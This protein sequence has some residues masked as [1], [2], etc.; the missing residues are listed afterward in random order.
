M[1][2][3]LLYGPKKIP[4]LRLC[5]KA[6]HSW[7]RPILLAGTFLLILTSVANAQS[8]SVDSEGSDFVFRITFSGLTENL[9]RCGDTRSLISRDGGFRTG[10][11][12]VFV[13]G[14]K[15]ADTFT[16]I[17]GPG[18]SSV[19]YFSVLYDGTDRLDRC[20]CTR[21]SV[22]PEIECH[23]FVDMAALLVTTAPIKAPVNVKVS[24]GTYQS[25]VV[26]TWQKGSDMP[27]GWL[28]YKI[29]RDNTLIA[30]L[31]PGSPLTYTDDNLQ[32]GEAHAYS[33]T[34]YTDVLQQTRGVFESA[35]QNLPGSTFSVAAQATSGE[36]NNR[37]KLIWN[38][39]VAL[40]T[41]EIRIERSMPAGGKEEIAVVS[42]NAVTYNDYDGIPGY[43]YT[44]TITPLAS[45]KTFLA[46]STTGYRRPN[47]KITGTVQSKF[48]AGVPGVIVSAT[49]LVNGQMV[50]SYDLNGTIIE[51]KDTT[52]AS[53]FY[54][55]NTVYYF[56]KAEF[57]LTAAKENHEFDPVTQ[58]R[59]LE[60]G[61]NSVNGVNFTDNTVF[62]IAGTVTDPNGC[63]V[64]G[65]TMLLDGKDIGKR[66]DTEG[67]Y[68][69]S[70]ENEGTYVV[71]PL[72][73]HH[74]FNKVSES[75]VVTEG[76]VIANFVD[77]QKDKV[78]VSL[79]SGCEDAVTS[80][81]NVNI[82][83]AVPS[84]LGTFCFDQT[85][86]ITG[87]SQE[88][89]LPAQKYSL[90]VVGASDNENNI[91]LQMGKQG[92][93]EIDLTQ[94]DTVNN[95]AV[96]PKAA[97]E[98]HEGTSVTLIV[99]P[100]VSCGTNYVMEQDLR[101]DVK[102]E[103]KEIN[104]FLGTSCLVDSGELQITD[105]VGDKG[106]VTLNAG[107]GTV[108]YR[109]TAG[110]PNI[111][112]PYT[113]R[114]E[115]TA[116]V[117]SAVPV[118]QSFNVIVTGGKPRVG[119][120]VTRTP[121]LPHLI[122]H[123]P[124]G[125]KSYSFLQKDS[126]YTVVS[127]TSVT[128][129]KENGAY[130][131][132]KIGGGAAIPF[133]V[134]VGGGLKL[135]SKILKGEQ[136][137]KG[138]ALATTITTAQQ[139]STA[140]T[141][142]FT[143]PQGDVFVG[144]SYNIRY[145]LIDLVKVVDCQVV[146]D[147][148]IFWNP[149]SIATTYTY[150]DYQIR[151]N[152][153]SQLKR[154]RDITQKR[155]DLTGLQSAKDTV[156]ILNSSI[157]V[158]QQVLDKN[159]LQR[160]KISNKYF[161]E[162]RSFSAGAAFT[163]SV[164]KATDTTNTYDFSVFIDKEAALG[165]FVYL[166]G[167]LSLDAGALIN[168]KWSTQ[169]TTD[170]SI[171]KSTTIGYH[172]DDDD[173][174]D[175]FSVD[176]YND[177]RY[178]TPLFKLNA[179]TSSCPNEPG[180]QTR[181]KPQIDLNR[182]TVSN[183]PAN[184]PAVF[185]A[186]IANI[187]ESEEGREYAVRVIPATNMDGA[188]IRM[189]GQ[190]ISTTPIVYFLQPGPS[191]PVTITVEKGPFAFNYENIKLIMYPE[192]EYA[193]FQNGG[194][195]INAD[196][197]T[198]SV[199][200][201]TQCSTVQISKP[202]DNWLINQGSDNKMTLTFT[203]YNVNNPSFTSIGLQF[204]AEGKNWETAGTILKAQ[205]IDQFKDFAW[206]V[207]DLSKYADGKYEIRAFATCETLGQTTYS[208][209]LKGII[210]RASVAPFGTPSPADGYLRQGQNIS[211]TFDKSINCAQDF[212]S[213]V[214]LIRKDN[215][216]TLPILIQCSDNTLIIKTDPESAI[217]DI[218]LSGIEL[219]ATVSGIE[220]NAGNVQK[221]P[222]IWS[223][224]VNV[225]P[226][227]WDPDTLQVSMMIRARTKLKAEL[228]NTAEISKSFRLTSYP[229]WLTPSAEKGVIQPFG[230]FQLEFALSTELK[231]GIYEGVINA[232]VDGFTEAMPV[233]LELLAVPVSWNVNPS[234]YNH[235]M[236]I[237][238]QY[239][240]S[241]PP[242]NVP[243]STDTRDVIGVFV[244]G[245]PR[246]VGKIRQV[247]GIPGKYAAFITV[248]SNEPGAGKETL[249]FRMWNSL[250]GVVYGAKET[251][252]FVA[253]GT[254]GT[255]AV[256]YI[257]HPE[258]IFQVIPLNKGWNWISFNV[259]APDMSREKIFSSLLSSG[260]SIQIKSQTD[261]S[262]FS[263]QSGWSGALKTINLT[264]GYMVY[265]SDFPDT[266]RIVGTNPPAGP[267][268]PVSL[269]GTWNWIGYPRI[270][271]AEIKTA[272]GASFSAKNGDALKSA[273]AFATFTNP[274]APGSWVGDLRT[275]D[276]G[277]GYKL[278]LSA[279][280]T[281]TY[282]RKAAGGSD[283]EVTEQSYEF[284]MTLTGALY[285]NGAESQEDNYTVGAFIDGVCR[286]FAQPEYIPQSKVYRVSLTIHGEVSDGGKAVEFKVF[287]GISNKTLAVNSTQVQFKLDQIIGSV[288]K[289]HILNQEEGFDNGYYLSQNKPN[290][291]SGNTT[292]SFT[293]PRDEP[294]K[295]T[296]TNQYGV[297]V[298]VLVEEQK[299]A[300]NHQVQLKSKGFQ[301]GMYMY[302]LKA[303]SYLKTRKLLII[304]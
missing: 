179:G 33:V 134:E 95:V 13:Q 148:S 159:D 187:N 53:G 217:N 113:K 91:L 188:V 8:I 132:A 177:P 212:S 144:A 36:Y 282:G 273:T 280:A 170:T 276:P 166:G 302:V 106:L 207:S 52:D 201:Q 31:N 121:E 112:A 147:V 43:V 84:G 303:G 209:V 167:F 6:A 61:L 258:G 243:V 214:S 48:G 283:F 292:I 176:I 83:S 281:L 35:K 256:P 38:N 295:L 286:G 60:Q 136:N 59:T 123:D 304:P 271:N 270:S 4:L 40:G 191:I 205:L 154:L 97:F 229:T 64:K 10:N 171:T 194:S 193:I 133:Y 200:F 294:V 67:K 242:G 232:E 110:L 162:N 100:S 41:E 227:F 237:V 224:K 296:L 74:A 82:R 58:K 90:Q 255:A 183:V 299:T 21:V 117:G 119:T 269:T 190:I 298:S 14:I 247:E 235:S 92:R 37:V 23:L 9:C 189:G 198:L 230:F 152:I 116:K 277:M 47:G 158:W 142:V 20:T 102:I 249:T 185:V 178:G 51:F 157:N 213:K 75:V 42:K 86:T 80:T 11:Q 228:K 199:N 68:Q 218:S 108:I 268:P 259:S 244:N 129:S 12:F 180:T 120:F 46:S 89:E 98:F 172:L 96:A 160:E 288:L 168:F 240:L 174:G 272:L 139:L 261:F 289:P 50:S 221:Y 197:V 128:S 69:L 219:A 262:N 192:C 124:M 107:N 79:L 49:G 254:L 99:D 71:K 204:R 279:P 63:P 275:M 257:L 182:Y 56:D 145:G 222:A 150:T 114:F 104:T 251:T 32:P 234:A 54:E 165:G 44:Y 115:V 103:V 163:S 181:D 175:F 195:I 300:G 16:W 135:E 65:V 211:V 137:L 225:K 126:S 284:N 101:Y 297:V 87:T 233:K 76:Q 206:D 253:D 143:G 94:R 27:D 267:L 55:I 285:W 287:N 28:K 93:L 290:P 301:S 66:T 266:L 164:T 236:N 169:T 231:P 173:I 274:P 260:N 252:P 77:T 141:D 88:I 30:T 2:T 151:T 149:E 210:D 125:D 7:K 202:N 81:F 72:Y 203:G 293:I 24:D 208:A 127:Q 153:L 109:L 216:S 70:V 130:L 131:N 241:D 29:Y 220:D 156:Q 73:Y 22:C 1:K 78:L 25:K 105:D 138:G 250:S 246:G 186:N 19:N 57:T 45:G 263:P 245:V 161:I 291:F 215:G 196:T 26:L 122:L 34:T 39:I 226:V 248:Y 239:T 155:A 264:S 278:K 18:Y 15:Q 118:T 238:A 184:E 5:L 223:F 146:P 85:I 62:T 3:H 111:V 140:D 17:A 265:L